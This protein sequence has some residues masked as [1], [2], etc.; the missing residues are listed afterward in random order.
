[1]AALLAEWTAGVRLRRWHRRLRAGDFE[2]GVLNSPSIER[3]AEIGRPAALYIAKGLSSSPAAAMSACMELEML[4][5]DSAGE[6]DLS[7]F[8][9]DVLD[10]LPAFAPAVFMDLDFAKAGA[11]DATKTLPAE[12][13][14][15]SHVMVSDELF[16]CESLSD[17][18]TALARYL[19]RFPHRSALESLRRRVIRQLSDPSAWFLARYEAIDALLRAI[20]AIDPEDSTLITSDLDVILGHLRSCSAPPHLVADPAGEVSITGVGRYCL[21]RPASRSEN[22]RQFLSLTLPIGADVPVE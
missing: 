15:G 4:R 8:L 21:R 18:T 6:A 3:L 7:R 9:G 17:L 11:V 12:F 14:L 20:Q 1:M 19:A 13:D 2:R 22:L 16:R 10:A 5:H